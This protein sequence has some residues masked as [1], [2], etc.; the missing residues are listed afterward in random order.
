MAEETLRPFRPSAANPWDRGKAAH[1][2]NRAGFG[3]TPE[4]I[5]RLAA[6]GPQAAVDE[7]LAY[8]QVPEALSSYATVL[9]RWLGADPKA[10]LGA[11]FERV[12][13]V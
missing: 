7:L 10:I 9:E 13:F 3:G 8:E 4:E 5:A 2:L 11:E 6:M 1:L 12:P